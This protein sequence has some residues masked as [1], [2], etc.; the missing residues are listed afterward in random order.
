MNSAKTLYAILNVIL[1]LISIGLGI[2]VLAMVLFG[3]KQDF[4]GLKYD[5]LIFK[6]E[7]MLYIFTFLELGVYAAFVVALLRLRKA[8]KLLLKNDFYNTELISE[9]FNSGKLM[10]LSSVALLLI[11]E[12]GNM[13][14]KRQVLVGLSEKTLVYLLIIAVGLFLML[15]STV[16]RDTKAIKEENDLT[17]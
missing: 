13:F 16:L 4:I 5:A 10:V 15:M 14:Y 2:F 6:T 12:I 11:D 8:T 7:A 9:I 1:I 17:V 3:V